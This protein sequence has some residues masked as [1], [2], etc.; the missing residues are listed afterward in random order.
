VSSGGSTG[1][2]TSGC[3]QA[4][5]YS[6][7]LTDC[8]AGQN[9]V[10]GQLVNFCSPQQA[11]V[12]LSGTF[13][14][15]YNGALVATNLS[16]GLFYFC[17]SPGESV[18]PSI[19][20][21]GFYPTLLPTVTPDGGSTFYN[22]VPGIDMLCNQGDAQPFDQLTNPTYMASLAS[23][24]VE[25]EPDTEATDPCI[26]MAGWVFTLALPDAGQLSAATAYVASFGGFDPTA[27][28]TGEEGAALIYNLQPGLNV[29]LIGSNPSVL[30]AG[31]DC[32]SFNAQFA[33]SLNLPLASGALTYVP[34]SEG[35]SQ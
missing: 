9:E 4:D 1:G 20:I 33:M 23:V 31:A 2:S 25:V 8:D 15:A 22:A 6:H 10:L 34:Y 7:P 27:T 28:A 26:T 14:D 11:P 32:V 24:L 17:L 5:V 18:T 19:T 35:D 29:Q 21:D 3:A 16:C 30:D 13:S 12:T